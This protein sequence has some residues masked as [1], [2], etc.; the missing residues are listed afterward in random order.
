MDIFTLRYLAGALVE[1]LWGILKVVGSNP[2]LYNILS[3]LF[4]VKIVLFA[5][6]RPKIN[7][8]EAGDGPFKKIS[9]TQFRLDVDFV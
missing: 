4:L 7:E 8:K 9:W 3:H 1:V 6:K 5:W 2:S